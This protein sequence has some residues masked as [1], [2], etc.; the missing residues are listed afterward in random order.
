VNG[1]LAEGELAS[2][3]F[4]LTQEQAKTAASRASLRI[5]LAGRLSRYHVAPLVAF[6]LFIAFVA[7]LTFTGL[8][9]RRLGEAALIVAAVAFMAAR[10]ITH[11]R[12]RAFQKSGAA[13]ANALQSSGP[14]FAR[15]DGSGVRI[16][17]AAGAVHFAFAD[18]SEAEEADGIIYLWPRTGSPAFIPAEAFASEEQ[19]RMFLVSVRQ[20]IKRATQR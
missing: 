7:I 17:S 13:A 15:L 18:C 4:N 1:D 2:A 14:M 11:W 20:G 5:A 3:P 8:M 12:M 9:A 16:E 19:A 6:A 10:M